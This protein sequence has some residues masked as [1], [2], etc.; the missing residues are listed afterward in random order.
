MTKRKKKILIVCGIGVAVLAILAGIGW[1]L[2]MHHLGAIDDVSGPAG[3]IPSPA[4]SLPPLTRGPADWPHWRGP[5]LDGKSPVTGIRRDWS[6]GLKKV[7]EVDYLCTG[8][9]AQTWSAPSVQ[10]NRLVVPG[11]DPERDHV[12]CLDPETG[13]LLWHRSYD[14]PAATSH[15]PGAR[16]TP[17]I[18]DDRVYTFGRSGVI[19]C[20]RLADGEP[21]WRRSVADLGGKEPRWGHSSSPVVHGDN[22][23]VQAGG[24][25]IAVAYDKMTGEVAWKSRSGDAGYAPVVAAKFGGKTV[26]L[27]FHGTGLAGLDPDTGA[28][29]WD[30]PWE[31]NYGVNATTPH[32]VGETV[33][34]TSGYRVGGAALKV[35]AS[36][37]EIVWRNKAISSHHS[38]PVVIDGFIYCYSGNSNQNRGHLKCVELATGREMWSTG[39]VG[40]GT[41]VLVDGHLLCLD[42][43]GGLYLVRPDP[44]KFVK[45]TEF[46]AAVTAPKNYVWTMPV[47]AN[48]KLYL[49]YRQR[50][51]CYDLVGE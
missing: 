6:G 3:A 23:I 45:V 27:A 21:V 32:V 38:D 30:V 39:D 10:G 15:G 14:A 33:F 46:P 44:E 48:G 4:A 22:V 35:S 42:I 41:L 37:A 25:A 19:A 13:E 18:D 24:E 29:V 7:W 5:T 1:R 26:L 9:P 47:V 12:F 20:W 16:A 28:A 8:S 17:F 49:R 36:S 11:R 51:I 50:L 34:I 31:T 40:W 43:K 2:L